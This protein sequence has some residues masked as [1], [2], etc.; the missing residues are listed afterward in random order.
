MLGLRSLQSPG[1]LPVKKAFINFNLKSLVPPAM[2]TN[3]QNLRTEPKA[4]GPDPTINTLMTFNV[5]LPIDSLFCPRLSCQVYDNCFAGFSQPMI[6]TFT[7]KVGD[8]IQELREERR[9][10]TEALEKIVSQL[11]RIA[12][13]QTVASFYD[14]KQKVDLAAI[15]EETSDELDKQIQDQRMNEKDKA[16]LAG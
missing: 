3:L 1:I 16:K 15:E 2:G 14:Y 6:G 12:E 9:T 10:E 11:N 13:G 4:P 5:P 7:I 8:L